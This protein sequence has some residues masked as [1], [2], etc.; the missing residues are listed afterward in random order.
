VRSSVAATDEI[1]DGGRADRADVREMPVPGVGRR[2]VVRGLGIGALM[3]VVATAASSAGPRRA[4]P[5][6]CSREASPGGKSRSAIHPRLPPGSS[7][8][9]RRAARWPA[10]S[11]GPR[12]S[13]RQTSRDEVGHH[14]WLGR[15]RQRRRLRARARGPRGARP[16][17]GPQSPPRHRHREGHPSHPVRQRRGEERPRLRE[18]RRRARATRGAHP[19]R[20]GRGHRAFLRRRREYPADDRGRRHRALGRQD[21]SLLAA[22][23]PGTLALPVRSTARTSPTGR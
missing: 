18:P 10:T 7:V 14:R 2:D 22:G 9:R 6:T 3:A 4:G 5:A 15:G 11:P 23:F 13:I 12:W 20:G 17:E 1:V 8:P 19:G 16:R 21:A